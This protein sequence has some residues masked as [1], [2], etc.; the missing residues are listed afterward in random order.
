[1]NDQYHIPDISLFVNDVVHANVQVQGRRLGQV[2]GTRS[3]SEHIN[4]SKSLEIYII[5]PLSFFTQHVV[6]HDHVHGLGGQRRLVH[7]FLT[8]E[9]S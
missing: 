3:P 4:C 5:A 9:N 2:L 1:M 6:G 7:E 8:C